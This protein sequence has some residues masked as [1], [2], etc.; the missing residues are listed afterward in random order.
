MHIII[1]I[2]LFFLKKMQ[3]W[4][5]NKE[6]KFLGPKPKLVG[7]LN[8]YSMKNYAQL[9]HKFLAQPHPTLTHPNSQS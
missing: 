5:K 4:T 3:Q 6:P 7:E 8:P 9:Q 1:F 2:L